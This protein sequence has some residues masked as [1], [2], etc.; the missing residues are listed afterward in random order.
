[1]LSNLRF[2]KRSASVRNRSMLREL[3]VEDVIHQ[4]AS[5][6]DIHPKRPG[7]AGDATMQFEAGLEGAVERHEN[8]GDDDDGKHG[9]GEE[10]RQ[11]EWTK[12]GGF[13]KTSDAGIVVIG[14]VADEKDDRR[15]EG[16]NHARL[17]RGDVLTADKKVAESEKDRA[18][19]VESRVDLGKIVNGH[20]FRRRNLAASA[21]CAMEASVS[22]SK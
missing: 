20:G 16:R 14:Q 22:P 5:D 11:V 13:D 12:P 17:V 3:D 8:E 2:P 9:V 1:M 19:A 7:P 4:H 6:R 15:G 18:K 21:T 10:E